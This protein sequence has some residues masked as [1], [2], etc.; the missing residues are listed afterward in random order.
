[1]KFFLMGFY[2]RRNYGD[3]VMAL[4]LIRFLLETTNADLVLAAD[5][6][7]FGRLVHDPRVTIAPR[8]LRSIIT[9]VRRTDVFIQGGGTI[10]HDDVQAS[11]GRRYW[12]NLFLWGVLFWMARLFGKRVLVIGAGIGPLRH[13]VSRTISRFAFAAVDAVMVRDQASYRDLLALTSKVKVVEGF[14]IASLGVEP[15]R[16]K[17]GVDD[18]VT[19]AVTPCCFAEFEPGTPQGTTSEPYWVELAHALKDAADT[20]RLRIRLVALFTGETIESDLN[21]CRI[22]GDIIGEAAEIT[23]YPDDLEDL[24]RMFQ[25]ADVVI[26]ARYHGMLLGYVH[27][28][29]LIAVCYHRKVRDLADEISLPEACVLPRTPPI[30]RAAWLPLLHRVISTRDQ[31]KASLE[32]KSSMTRAAILRTLAVADVP[33][34]T[35]TAGAGT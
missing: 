21:V 6:A 13:V 10:F 7:Y 29:R 4:Q 16:A 22:M 30:P 11:I 14:D 28:C 27:G 23:S 9:A 19:V 31:P 33:H 1:M 12:L 5:G 2:G 8:T 3:D 17:S 35:E 34:R 15:P 20:R 18:A 26:S 25:E 32:E 24:P